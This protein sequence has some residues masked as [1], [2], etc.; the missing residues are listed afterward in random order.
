MQ[1][2]KRKEIR[3]KIAF[4]TSILLEQLLSTKRG[5]IIKDYV[6]RG[7][8]IPYITEITLT[9]TLY[10]LCRHI[11]WNRA[12]E[13]VK[14]LVDSGFFI[15]EDLEHVR[16]HA[17]QYKC[18]RRISLADC[19]TLGLAKYISAPALFTFKEKEIIEENSKEPFDIEIIFLDDIYKNL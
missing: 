7:E 2:K 17:A 9:E 13:K 10:V 18:K 3:G 1:K 19:F 15:V 8:I 12:K 11:G 6:V 5:I 16:E 14:L 4:D